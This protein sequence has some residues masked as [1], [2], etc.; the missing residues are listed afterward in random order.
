MTELEK[1][2][3]A[4]EYLDK[5][6]EGI[7][8]IS[9][10]TLLEDSVLNHVRLSRCF[11]YVSDVLGR[12]I[13]NGGV[14]VRQR[15]VKP[16]DLVPFALPADWRERVE[17]TVAPVMIRHFTERVNLLIDD[18]VMKP[19]KVTAFTN[20]LVEKGFLCE[21]II[22]DK[23]RKKPTKEGEKMGIYTEE[24]SGQHGTYMAVLYK[25]EAQR[26][27]VDHLEEITAINS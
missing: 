2:V 9:G 25:E 3:R 14:V 26:F 12:V 1:M 22:N 6:A 13:E 4:K 18:N 5:L 16:G 11:F 24:R 8:P 19:L 27:M 17:I 21:E 10:E 23:R 7:D 15:R 20:W